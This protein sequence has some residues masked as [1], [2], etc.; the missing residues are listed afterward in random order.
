MR[1]VGNDHPALLQQ[2]KLVVQIETWLGIG[3]ARGTKE[4]SGPHRRMQRD[5]PYWLFFSDFLAEE[6]SI[7]LMIRGPPTPDIRAA[8]LSFAG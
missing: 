2:F 8:N 7:T 1:V 3:G 4:Y 6:A 5:R